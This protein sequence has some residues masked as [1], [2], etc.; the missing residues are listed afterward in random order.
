M[1]MVLGM[2]WG[3]VRGRLFPFGGE[4][5]LQLYCLGRLGASGQERRVMTVSGVD[6]WVVPSYLW[7]LEVKALCQQNR[8]G[9]LASVG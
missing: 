8:L 1:A 9:F 5:G 6:R 3:K 7:Q 2:F 4:E